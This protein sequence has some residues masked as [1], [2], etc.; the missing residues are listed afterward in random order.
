MDSDSQKQRG[1]A[2]SKWLLILAALVVVGVIVLGLVLPSSRSSVIQ[3]RLDAIKRAGEPVTFEDLAKVYP[4]LPDEQNSVVIYQKAF[5]Q[6]VATNNVPTN[7]P[8]L[9]ESPNP[10][11]YIPLPPDARE[12]IGNYLQLNQSALESLHQAAFIERS[13]YTND[14]RSGPLGVSTPPM[15]RIRLNAQLLALS[16]IWNA[17]QGHS[18][19]AAQ[20]ITDSLR[21]ANSLKDSPLLISQIIRRACLGLSCDSLE[22]ALNRTAFSAEELAN[23]STAYHA[24]E[25]TDALKP[26]LMTDRCSGIN[27]G[28][29]LMN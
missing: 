6:C 28:K 13:Y 1:R 21:L 14:F 8:I 22:R 11:R 9:G 12:G 29:Q 4:P 19:E 23:L 26:C 3:A 15:S 20:A 10:I 25:P 2:R 5:A 24:A 7:W 17:D 16:A 18:P 27:F